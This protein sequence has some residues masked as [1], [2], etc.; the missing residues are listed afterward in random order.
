MLNIVSETH[1][2]PA[3]VLN[4]FP[5]AP[6]TPH[7]CTAYLT[8]RAP[9]AEWAQLLIT[10]LTVAYPTYQGA[11]SYNELVGAIVNTG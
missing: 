8:I 10:L 9:A 11:K 3:S 2:L 1:F 5:P 6:L 4:T 7:F